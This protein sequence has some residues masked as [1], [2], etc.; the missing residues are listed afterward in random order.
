MEAKDHISPASGLTH[1]PGKKLSPLEH[2]LPRLRPPYH[3]VCEEQMAGLRKKNTAAAA[4]LNPP[5]TSG[6]TSLSPM[7]ASKKALKARKKKK[8]NQKVG[9]RKELEGKL[10]LYHVIEAPNGVIVE[11]EFGIPLIIIVR[12]V[13]PQ[14]N[15][16]SMNVS[17]SIVFICIQE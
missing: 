1:A 6:R 16:E 3:A 15:M 2:S 13:F 12:N 8:K 5:P 7:S 10:D 14:T 17:E 9:V 4:P 11:D